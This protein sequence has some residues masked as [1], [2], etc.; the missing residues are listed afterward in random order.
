MIDRQP[1]APDP[2]PRIPIV[3]DVLHCVSMTALVWLRSGFSYVFLGPKSVFFA[4]SWAVMLM[5]YIARHEPAIWPDVRA[6]CIFAVGGAILYWIHLFYAWTR[7]L[8]RTDAYSGTSHL[9]FFTKWTTESWYWKLETKIQMVAE[10]VVV[11]V[12]AVILRTI[13][14]EHHLSA[15]LVVTA[16]AMSAK[17]ALNYWFEVRRQKRREQMREEIEQES[18]LKHEQAGRDS[19]PPKT[20]RKP[21]KQRQR[22]RAISPTANDDE[23]RY[24]ELLQLPD[25]YDLETVEQAYRD[26]IKRVHPDTHGDSEEATRRTAALNEAVEYFRA[27]LAR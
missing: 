22:T 9:L 1:A 4:F 6:L 2:T 27:R 17:S 8:R 20:T 23:K 19:E 21:P 11:L 25:S 10:P 15:W 13:F 26:V 12:V 18:E 16:T 3:S 7:E 24:A 5:S 14:S